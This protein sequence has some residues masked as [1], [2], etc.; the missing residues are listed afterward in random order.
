MDRDFFYQ[1]YKTSIVNKYPTKSLFS[2]SNE[3]CFSLSKSVV[4]SYSVNHKQSGMKDL[5]MNM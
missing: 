5:D 1:R 2:L 4:I 3:K